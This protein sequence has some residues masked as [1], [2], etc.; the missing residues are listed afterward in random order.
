MSSNDL[1]E[2]PSPRK[3]ELIRSFLL[4]TRVQ[5][6]IDRG[7][8]LDSFYLNP[9]WRHGEARLKAQTALMSV[10]GEYRSVWQ[11]EYENRVHWQ[12]SEKDLAEI[13]SFLESPVGL[14]FV[15]AQWRIHAYVQTNT[16]D[17]VTE[18]IDKANALMRG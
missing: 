5:S 11:D 15:P 4:L 8:F 17:L 13:V 16:E 6:E 14:K 18:I 12:F 10:Y 9:E 3:L 2:T 7:A 1:I